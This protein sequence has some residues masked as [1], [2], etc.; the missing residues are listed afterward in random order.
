M[1]ELKVDKLTGKTSTGDITVTSEGGA[2]TMQ[3]QQGLAKAWVNFDGGVTTPSV[4]EGLNSSSITDYGSGDYSV[5]LVSAMNSSTYGRLVSHNDA[6]Y[7][8]MSYFHGS[9]GTSSLYRVLARQ[10]HVTTPP[11]QDT[12]MFATLFGDLA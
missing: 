6:I 11:L 7:G 8:G 3:L 9:T 1:S 2:A 10:G 12:D 5:S 4:I